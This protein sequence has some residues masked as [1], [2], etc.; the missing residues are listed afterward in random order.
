M[1]KRGRFEVKFYTMIYST[2]L[3]QQRLQVLQENVEK[4]G[5]MKKESVV[6]LV[7][8]EEGR[9]IQEK[10]NRNQNTEETSKEF[11]LGW[12]NFLFYVYF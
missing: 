12:M 1:F 4:S 10:T 5:K 7:Y 8:K 2:L 9:F 3:W 11:C 6:F